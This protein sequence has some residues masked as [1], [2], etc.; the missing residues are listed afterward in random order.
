M[1]F[2]DYY[3]R[4]VQLYNEKEY[5]L[6]VDLARQFLQVAPD[7]GQ[8]WQLCG[9]A[10]WRLNDFAG[11]LEALEEASV[12]TPLHPLAQYALAACYVWADLP[13]LAGVIYEH[14]GDTV[15]DAS[16]LAMVAKSFGTLGQHEAAL[17]VCRRIVALDPT[18]HTAFFGI[19]YYLG[20]LGHQPL[21]LIGPL[22]MAVGL[23]PQVLHYRINLA[24]AWSDAG[25]AEEAYDLL[26]SVSVE[27]VNCPCCLRRMQG[28]FDAVGDCGRS[29]T[30][31]VR[32]SCL[33]Q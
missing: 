4:V 29:L 19:A 11:A 10:C 26:K 7:D 13:D 31:R 18:Y 23:A 12:L 22:A 6:A 25:A 32:L 21:T 24:L 33:L 1:A 2:H 27:A 5:A 20:C 16:L 28:V 8:L 14:L 9:T 17:H 15:E 30:C 3:H